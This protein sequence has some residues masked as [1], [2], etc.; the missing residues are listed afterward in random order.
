MTLHSQPFSKS[1]LGLHSL[2][3]SNRWRPKFCFN[4]PQS[5]L[6]LVHVL[7]ALGLSVP[8]SSWMSLRQFSKFLAIFPDI[9][10][11]HCVVVIH[12][13]HLAVNFDDRNIS[14]VFK[15][16]SGLS[17]LTRGWCT[18]LAPEWILRHLLPAKG[19]ASCEKYNA[20]LTT[21]YRLWNLTYRIYLIQTKLYRL[22]K[23]LECFN[24]SEIWCLSR[25]YLKKLIPT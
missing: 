12:I 25:K 17:I 15:N 13:S 10:H 24:F 20:G 4:S 21:S 18:W 2:T 14:K 9:R 7:H 5:V 11:S 3:L 1:H 22:S 16:F 19:V 6:Q 8:S 23:A